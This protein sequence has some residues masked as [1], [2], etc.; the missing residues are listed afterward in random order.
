MFANCY[1]VG[2]AMSSF[3][4]SVAI[5]ALVLTGVLAVKIIRSHD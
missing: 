1:L 5:C 3:V 2:V 4:I